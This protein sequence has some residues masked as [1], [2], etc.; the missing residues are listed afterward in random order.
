MPPAIADYWADRI[1][2]TAADVLGVLN[3]GPAAAVGL[4]GYFRALNAA[5]TGT[6]ALRN[7]G[8]EEDPHP[9]DIAR[10]YL[11][12]ETVRLLSFSGAKGWADRLEAEANRDV[13][14]IWLGETEV[15]K[16][17]AKASAAIVARTIVQERM[18]ALEGHAVGEVQDWSD[19]DE[20]V[21]A[22]LRRAMRS[23]DSAPLARRLGEDAYAAHAV[24]AAVYEAVEGTASPAQAQDRM[25]AALAEMHG[26]EA[27]V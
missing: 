20:S 17:A 6:P 19:A 16:A 18:R 5:Y 13:G 25:V 21:V 9:A 15:T 27:R 3:M 8:R 23:G 11:A 4:V 1:D 24:A 26:E 2:E 12:E 22:E 10:A 14:R 7:V